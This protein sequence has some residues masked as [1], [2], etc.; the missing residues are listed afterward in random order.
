MMPVVNQ[1]DLSVFTLP[2]LSLSL[3]L[4]LM[5]LFVW[6]F[7][8]FAIFT[9]LS[10]VSRNEVKNYATTMTN[11]ILAISDFGNNEGMQSVPSDMLLRRLTVV[12]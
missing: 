2:L 6:D 4:L 7:T 8:L 5:L 3:L 9:C 10:C 11:V 12:Y 1:L